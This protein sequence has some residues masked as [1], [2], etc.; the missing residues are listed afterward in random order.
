MVNFRMWDSFDWGMFAFVIGLV[1][2]IGTLI[3]YEITTVCAYSS[4]SPSYSSSSAASMAATTNAINTA[5]LTSIIIASSSN[6]G[7][8][9]TITC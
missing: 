9:G 5:L 7:G 6:S 2:V 4:Y 8:N 3:G 1:I